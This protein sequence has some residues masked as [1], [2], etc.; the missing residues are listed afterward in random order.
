[1]SFLSDL[2]PAQQD[3]VRAVNGPVM[4]IAGAGS[5]KTRVLTYRIAH[6]MT[7][8]VPPSSIL[9][10]TFTNKAAGEM[11]S[12]IGSLAGEKAHDLWMGTFHSMFARILRKEGALLGYTNSYT[13]YDSDDSLVA[14]K[15]AMERLKL[16][17]QQYNPSAIRS[18][19]SYAKNQMLSPAE[20]L[21]HSRDILE[22][23]SA[24]VYVEYDK[25]LRRS[26]AMD[27][28]DLLL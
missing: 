3:A 11:R 6:L 5:G 1:M 13:I 27:F 22:E 10:L 16:S 4:I 24:R 7:S 17:T 18:R 2:N 9:A 12:R 26:N 8:G 28:D 19:I 15:G 25:A 14:V 21:E 20:A 23:Q